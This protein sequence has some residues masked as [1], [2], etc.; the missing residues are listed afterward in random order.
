MNLYNDRFF[1]YNLNF[2][3]YEVYELY[4]K[5]T[6]QP[7]KH[8]RIWYLNSLDW[9]FS[10]MFLLWF[11]WFCS[12]S[13]GHSVFYYGKFSLS[14]VHPTLGCQQRTCEISWSRDVGWIVPRNVPKTSTRSCWTVGQRAR[15]SVPSS[16]RWPSAS[17]IVWNRIS[18]VV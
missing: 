8:S 2:A 18:P 9:C 17:I 11:F 5:Y 13:D 6:F 4:S 1:R 3:L 16:R 14:V 12:N 15:T 10:F 7:K